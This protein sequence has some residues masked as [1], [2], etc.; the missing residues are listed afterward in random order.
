MPVVHL[1]TAEEVKEVLLA[2][3]RQHYPDGKCASAMFDV[4]IAGRTETLV[5]TPHVSSGEPVPLFPA[6]PVRTAS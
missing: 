6:G 2:Y 1:V 4:G 5:V 3:Q